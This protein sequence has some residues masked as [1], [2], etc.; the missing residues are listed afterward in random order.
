[1]LLDSYTTCY[2]KLFSGVAD[3]HLRAAFEVD[4]R[5]F[6]IRSNTSRGSADVN[7]SLSCEEDDDTSKQVLFIIVSHKYKLI[8]AYKLIYILIF[9]VYIYLMNL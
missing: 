1:M 4:F 3:T 6:L 9:S 5:P 2:I 7:L 8:Q